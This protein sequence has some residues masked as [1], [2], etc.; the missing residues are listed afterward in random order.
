MLH[1]MAEVGTAWESTGMAVERRRGQ[2]VR[3]ARWAL[4]GFFVGAVL[5]L[6]WLYAQTAAFARAYSGRILPGTVLSGVDVGGMT[7]RQ[8]LEA[9]QAVVEPQLDRTI[10]LVH[11]DRTWQTTPRKLGATSDA[12]TA[13]SD[14]VTHSEGIGWG[15]WFRMRWLGKDLGFRRN[16]ARVQDE[17]AARAVVDQIAAE[18]DVPVRDA[19]ID[20]SSGSFEIRSEQAG[21]AVAPQATSQDLLAA[22]S[23]GREVVTVQS[24]EIMPRATTAAFG[25]VLL[26]RQNE[27]RL[28]LYEHGQRTHDWLVATG[29]GGFPTPTGQFEVAQKRSM[30]TWV[31]PDPTG[32]GKDMPAEIAPG[33]GNPLGVRALNWSRVGGIRFHGTSNTASLGQSASHGCV[34][35]SNQDVAQLYDLVNVGTKIV[36]LR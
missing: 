23:D 8:A 9:V 27:H 32:W 21:L 12:A 36:S 31:N 3:G 25:K 33:P 5:C 13:L 16:V 17:R 15:G 30:P 2:L 34:R 22:L 11:G 20:P 26:L 19:S 18:V 14:A 1:G 10:T 24:L 28:Y 4:V 6:A 29:T 7:M 35:L